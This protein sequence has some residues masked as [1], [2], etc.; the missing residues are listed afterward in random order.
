VGSR[1][2][3]GAELQ[4]IQEGSIC[5]TDFGDSVEGVARV[6]HRLL[7]QIDIKRSRAA[8][9]VKDNGVTAR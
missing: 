3:C 4:D 9:P 2:Q 5:A 7:R 1:A 8:R 6:A